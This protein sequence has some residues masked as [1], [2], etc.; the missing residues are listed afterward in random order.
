MDW[1][2]ETVAVGDQ[3]STYNI[4]LLL[5]FKEY[6]ILKIRMNVAFE[7]IFYSN[8]LNNNEMLFYMCVECKE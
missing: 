6:A 7:V 2:I 4:N 8:R 5:G 1:E 3:E